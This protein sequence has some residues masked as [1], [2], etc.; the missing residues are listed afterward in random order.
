L[1]SAWAFDSAPCE[2]KIYNIFNFEEI[3]SKLT[4]KNNEFYFWVILRHKGQ[5]R[6]TNKSSEFLKINS[7]CSSKG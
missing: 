5:K 2:N 3:S 4:A 7:V 1:K 6:L